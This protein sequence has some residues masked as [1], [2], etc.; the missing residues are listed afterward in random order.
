MRY[1]HGG[2]SGRENA[3][4]ILSRRTMIKAT[5]AV[6]AAALPIGVA[7]DE[8]GIAGQGIGILATCSWRT[9]WPPAHL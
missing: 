5:G 1:G 8:G 6:G 9:N 3:M 4:R 7:P 2:Q